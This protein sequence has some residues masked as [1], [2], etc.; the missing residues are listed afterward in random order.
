MLDAVTINQLRAFVAV[1]DEGTFSGA[2]KRLS[3]AQSA[4]SHAITALEGRV[5]SA[6]SCSS[7]IRADRRSHQCGSYLAAGTRAPVISRTEE[8][9]NRVR[10]DSQDRRAANPELPKR[11][12]HFHARI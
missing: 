1:C 2:A 7:A 11:S 3:R 4:I 5:H 6:S 8:M 10:F 9:K 12:H